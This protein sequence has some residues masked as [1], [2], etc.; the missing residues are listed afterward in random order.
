MNFLG[1]NAGEIR[2]EDA[3]I[4]CRP[5]KLGCQPIMDRD[6]YVYFIYQHNITK[7]IGGTYLSTNT[8]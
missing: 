4:S 8:I 7:N 6:I 3:E 1:T 5:L 2:G